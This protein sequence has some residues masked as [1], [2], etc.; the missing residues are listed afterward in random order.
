MN[1]FKQPHSWKLMSRSLFHFKSSVLENRAIP[2]ENMSLFSYFLI[3]CKCMDSHIHTRAYMSI[4]H[5]YLLC[6]SGSSESA[7]EISGSCHGVF[8]AAD[9]LWH[10]GWKLLSSGHHHC[11]SCQQGLERH[12]PAT[13]VPAVC[14]GT[15]VWQRADGMCACG[16]CRLLLQCVCVW[17]DKRRQPAI[18]PDRDRYPML[19][20]FFRT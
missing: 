20:L 16:G 14:V 17:A 3:N 12:A 2:M 4:P 15:P 7:A 19:C 5:A 8:P 18:H 11:V 6:L 1:T 9:S 13:W 10:F